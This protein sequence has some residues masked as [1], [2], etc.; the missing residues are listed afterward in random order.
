MEG[1]REPCGPAPSKK[2][3][4]GSRIGASLEKITVKGHVVTFAEIPGRQNILENKGTGESDEV[5]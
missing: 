2:G 1:E 5:T 4:R 3:Y